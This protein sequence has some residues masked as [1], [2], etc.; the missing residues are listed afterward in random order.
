MDVLGTRRLATGGM[1]ADG[2]LSA[3]LE[4]RKPA[5]G[6][7]SG[8]EARLRHALQ[9]KGE[10]VVYP[11]IMVKMALIARRLAEHTAAG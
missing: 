9:K 3:N 10:C 5:V 7:E 8:V 6:G 4:F 1:G 2:T 11:R